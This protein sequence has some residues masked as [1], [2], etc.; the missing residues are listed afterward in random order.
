MP[1][2]TFYLAVALCAIASLTQAAWTGAPSPHDTAHLVVVRAGAFRTVEGEPGELLKEP[3]AAFDG[4]A[5]RVVQPL[6]ARL[7][8]RHA[9][10]YQLWIRLAVSQKLRTSL[11]L[12]VTLESGK[13][14][15]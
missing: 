11:P 9:G 14:T 4:Q 12:Q 15:L 10:K 6:L 5:V 8:V 1:T 13:K 3:G 7:K 2:R